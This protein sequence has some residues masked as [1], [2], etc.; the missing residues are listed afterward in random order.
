MR[1]HVEKWKFWAGTSH[2]VFVRRYFVKG[3]E[4]ILGS[5]M[6]IHGMDNNILNYGSRFL[7][8]YQDKSEI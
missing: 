2:M 6:F 1:A 3:E 4:N 7:G 8:V 5:I